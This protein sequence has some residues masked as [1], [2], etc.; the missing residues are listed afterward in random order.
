MQSVP[1]DAA[2]HRRSPVTM[3]GFHE[4]RAPRNKGHR[5]PADPPTVEEIIAVMRA[6]GNGADGT[7]LRALIVILWR[8]GLRI[9]EALDLAETDLDAARGAVLV[10]R[11]KGGRRRELGMDRWAWSQL[12]PWLAIRR[13]LRRRAAVPD[14][15]CDCWWSLGII[16]G[17]QATRAHRRQ[18]RRS[19]SV[20]TA[21]APPRSR[22]RDVPRRDLADRDPAS[23]RPTRQPRRYVHLPAGDRQVGD[24]SHRPL[25]ARSD[26]PGDCWP[27]AG[28]LV[29]YR[30]IGH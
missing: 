17:T 13:D 23:A 16:V 24:H 26:D 28:A 29:K 3:P 2:G 1:L 11:G 30:Q 8:A 12:E 19:P 9:G 18:G 20:R 4:G 22:G 15:R 10:R 6:A 21:L 5:Y 14:P 27:W 25:A 7:R